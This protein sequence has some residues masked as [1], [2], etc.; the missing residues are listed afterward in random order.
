MVWGAGLGGRKVCE[1]EGPVVWHSGRAACGGLGQ[2]EGTG[3]L[4]SSCFLSQEGP[5]IPSSHC[6]IDRE[7]DPIQ[8]LVLASEGR[9]PGPGAL[10]SR[11]EDFLLS[12][13]ECSSEMCSPRALS[14]MRRPSP[15]G[16][17]QVTRVCRLR[18]IVQ[19]WPEQRKWG[20]APGHG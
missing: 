8:K 7:A 4:G 11:S 17:W 5:F 18:S 10:S 15:A 9:Q 1:E 14:R 20:G 6:C 3:A 16:G 13:V 19:V 12:P 2:A